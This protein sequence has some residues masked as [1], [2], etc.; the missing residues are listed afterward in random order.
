MD[1]VKY[2]MYIACFAII[3]EAVTSLNYKHLKSNALLIAYHDLIEHV[4]YV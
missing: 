1:N 3:S 4:K 2:K